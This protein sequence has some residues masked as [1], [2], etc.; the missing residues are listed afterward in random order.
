MRWVPVAGEQ[1]GQR[2][3]EGAQTESQ[4]TE[5]TLFSMAEKRKET[6]SKSRG[7]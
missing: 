1:G 2:E 4:G 5:N 7:V 3:Q 6:R